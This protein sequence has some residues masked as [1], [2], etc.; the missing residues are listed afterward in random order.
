MAEEQIKVDVS[1]VSTIAPAFPTVKHH[2]FLSSFD[3]GA[4][5]ASNMRMLFFYKTE[6]IPENEFSTIV[7][8]LKRSL[9]LVLV[10]FYPFAGR[11]DM[12]G[13]ESGRPEVD[14]NDGGV[15]FVE[16]SINMTLQDLEDNNFQYKNFFNQLVQMRHEHCDASLLSIQVTAFVRCGICIGV[17]AHHVIA[18]GVSF[19]QFME[20]WA[21]CTR[22]LPIS[23]KPYHMREVFKRDYVIP[24]ISL[25][26]KQ[27]AT[28]PCT[29]AHIIT[30]MRDDSLPVP[31]INSRST[32]DVSLL[33][34]ENGF[35][36]IQN[37]VQEDTTLEKSTF[38]FSEIM[39][40][41]LKERSGASSSFVAV[42]AQ[43]WRS[44]MI[45][46]QVPEKEPVYFEVIADGRGRVKPPL[47]PTYFGNC[48]SIGTA[49]TTTRQLL[50]QDISF[51]AT[52]IQEAI[53]SCTTEEH[54]NN[55]ID[56]FESHLDSKKGIVTLGN[57]VDARYLVYAMN[58]PKFPAYAIDH[59]FGSPLSVQETF[60]NLYSVQG[61]M[62]FVAGIGG[63]GISVSTQLPHHQM[64]TLKRILMI[65]PD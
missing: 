27:V 32:G 4:M 16:A 31:I 23:K 60:M 6:L 9:S 51:A 40:Q 2:M 13:G 38:H 24:N 43:F 21:E 8:S 49:R 57:F 35:K 11:L 44:V 1:G 46:R 20:C 5:V 48:I 58:S 37:S 65:I 55:Q 62:M 19:W 50:E 42:S 56:W 18:D 54:I 26:A 59:G 64:E 61:G 29:E 12:K 30:F 39:I 33:N 10:D 34:S 17:N 53:K 63:R 41:N 52:L 15:E 45:A 36:D 14:C 47:P 25:T 3:L 7:E 28:H 22:G